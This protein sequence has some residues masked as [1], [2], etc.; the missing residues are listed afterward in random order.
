MGLIY[1]AT[2]N[3]LHKSYIGQTSG[4]LKSRKRKHLYSAFNKSSGS[5]YYSVF[6][7]ML[8]FLGKENFIWSI[9]EENIP[10]EELDF[11]EAY[12]IRKY[13]TYNNGYNSSM[14]G[15]Y[16]YN[17]KLLKNTV[18]TIK[19]NLLEMQNNISDCKTISA[20]SKKLN[21][22]RDIISDI[23]CG[24]TWF[25]DKTVYP[26]Y[27]TTVYTYKCFSNN[28]ITE[29]I[30]LLKDKAIPIYSIAKKFKCSPITISKINNG[31][32]LYKQQGET[33]PIRET[34]KHITEKDI[35]NVVIMLVN[36]PDKLEREIGEIVQ[37][38]RH[39][40]AS[41]NTG[42]YHSKKVKEIFSGIQFPIRENIE[43]NKKVISRCTPIHTEK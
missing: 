4:T 41:I 28:E 35:S 2:D 29:I 22:S 3:I 5:A 26:I 13:D 16:S 12:Y 32:E 36:N 43:N 8:R 42:A 21:I 31:Q 18:N 1:I 25:D 7:K 30:S 39:V 38:P 6:Y 34:F 24:E 9:L 14:G 27:N 15:R 11:K 33:Y 23:N 10:A 19:Q 40:V 20:L 17:A 37:V